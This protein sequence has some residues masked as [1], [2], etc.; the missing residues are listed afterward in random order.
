MESGNGISRVLSDEMVLHMEIQ[1]LFDEML[2]KV[3]DREQAV[4]QQ[5][6]QGEQTPPRQGVMGLF[7]SFFKAI[8]N[9]I[10]KE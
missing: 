1:D 10:I 4:T 9:K 2:K 6:T 5:E 7:R 3:Q 8:K